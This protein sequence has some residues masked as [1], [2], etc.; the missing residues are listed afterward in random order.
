MLK[1]FYNMLYLKQAEEKIAMEIEYI[2]EEMTTT[3]NRCS[4]RTIN[5]REFSVH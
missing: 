1:S 2:T 5:L 4:Y 3:Y